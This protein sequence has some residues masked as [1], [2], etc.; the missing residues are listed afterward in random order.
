MKGF[1]LFLIVCYFGTN[2]DAW[3]LPTLP[4]NHFGS[5]LGQQALLGSKRLLAIS[6]TICSLYNGV[7]YP[8]NAAID[9]VSATFTDKDNLVRFNH[10]LS[11]KESPKLVKTHDKEYF[12]LSDELKGLNTGVTIDRIRKINNIREFTTPEKLG[13]KVVDLEL[14]KDGVSNCQLLSATESLYSDV[15]V[16][17]IQYT[18]QSS[19]GNN[20]Y[21]V[22]S[23]VRDKQL[24]V[25]TVQV[26]DKLYKDNEDIRDTV[27]NIYNSFS[28]V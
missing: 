2:L 22:K 1:L 17:N 26:K 25:F 23:F 16:Y 14:S 6:F 5:K 8:V 28:V 11:M 4:K 3:Q 19:H 21:F 24:I 12:F 7:T 10:P 20:I 27:D 13:Q 15:P 9:T 18:V